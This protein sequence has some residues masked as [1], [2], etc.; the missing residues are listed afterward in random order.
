MTHKIVAET[1]DRMKKIL[2]ATR[3]E[4]AGIRTGKATPSLLDLIRVE[5]YGQPVPLNQVGSVAAPEP[6]LLIVQPWDKSL[7]KAVSKAI[8][9]SDLGLNPTDDGTVVRVPIPALTEERR[10]DLVKLVARLAEEGRVHVR[11]VRHDVNK[12]IKGQESSG[13]T[14]ED[15]A[16]RLVAEV[17]KL[18]DRYIG[19]IDE[20]LK[21]KTAEVMEV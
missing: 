3:R 9:A 1:E 16:K 13:A 12:D 17:Q 5:A 10:R 20:V 4:L 19:M 15:D 14:S 7:V 6:R 2:E 21:K 18:T 8:Q 11:Q